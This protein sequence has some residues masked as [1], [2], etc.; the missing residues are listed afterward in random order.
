MSD[1]LATCLEQWFY[2]RI[3]KSYFPDAL[4]NAKVVPLHKEG[5]K[6]EQYTQTGTKKSSLQLV[7]TGVPQGSILGTILFL[8]YI[9][10]FKS[11]QN[12]TDLILYA[13]DSHYNKK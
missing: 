6:H 9:N 4:K 10:E 2:R 13:D 3:I 11:M 1:P 8:I 7:E 12:E 5:D